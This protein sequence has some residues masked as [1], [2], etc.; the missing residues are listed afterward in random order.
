LEVFEIML[1]KQN[2]T[3]A[4]FITGMSGID[5]ETQSLEM[6]AA[7]FMRKPIRREALLPRVASILQ[8]NQRNV[9]ARE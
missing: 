5:V 6:G 3:P 2:D 7:G 1:Q 8:R 4:L 9:A